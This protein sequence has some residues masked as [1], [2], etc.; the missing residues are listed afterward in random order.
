MDAKYVNRRGSAQGCAFSESQNQKLTC[1]HV[2]SISPQSR[3][4]GARYRR[5]I[6]IEI[7][8][9]KTVL[10]LGMP[11][12]DPLKRHRSAIF[13]LYSEYANRGQRFQ[14]MWKICIGHVIR[15]MHIGCK[16]IVSGILW[17]M[18]EL[19]TQERIS[20]GSSNLVEGLI[21]W[22]APGMTTDQS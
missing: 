1:S 5:Y 20:I 13:G 19:I 14:N 4:F 10:A 15:R 7:F 3:H 11:R 18:S 21:T 16:R 17:E 8:A 6:E 9:W 12:V 2:Q 22:P